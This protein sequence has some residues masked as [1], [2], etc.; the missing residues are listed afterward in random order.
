MRPA[1]IWPSAV[2]RQRDQGVAAVGVEGIGRH[3]RVGLKAEQL[4]PPLGPGQTLGAVVVR[5]RERPRD[6]DEVAE[7]R[8]RWACPSELDATQDVGVVPDDDVRTR[9]NGGA[10]DAALVHLDLG[11]TWPMPLCSATSTTS[12]L[13]RRAVM[14]SCMASRLSG[15]AKV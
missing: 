3:G 1:S 10:A 12:T 13:A 6:T 4:L 7:G 5:H 15:A 8:G 14:S 11:G 2:T 9:I